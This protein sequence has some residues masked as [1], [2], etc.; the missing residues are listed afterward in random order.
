MAQPTISSPPTSD[1]PPLDALDAI[2]RRVLWLAMRMID[3][4]NRERPNP[5]AVKVGGHQASSASMVTLMTAMYFHW[6]EAGDRVAVKPHASPVLHS[7]NYLLGRLDRR[8][9]TTLRDFG[10]L[11]SY[12]SRTKDPDPVDFSTG[13]VGLGAAAPLF[14]G[15][16]D[17][18]L[19][20]QF[21]QRSGRRFVALVGDAELDEGNVWEAISD[22]ATRGLGGV[23]WIIDFNRQSLDRVVPGIRS[24]ELASVFADHGWHVVTLKYGPRLRAAFALDGGETL[25]KRI[26]EMPNGEYQSLLRRPGAEIRNALVGGAR[27]AHRARLARVLEAYPDE[28]LAPLIGDLGGHDLGDV[29]DGLRACDAETERPSVIFA[30]TVKGWGL[31]I[32]GHPL[33]HSAVLSPAQIDELRTALADAGDEWAG[34]DPA[35]AEGELCARSRARMDEDA[36]R[37]RIAL[38]PDVVP[39]EL[40]DTWTR[41]TSSQEAFARTLQDLAKIEP[42]ARHVVTT[43]PDV[44]ISTGLGG[45]INRR[46][47][48]AP[49]EERVYEQEQSTPLRWE[50]SPT[51][52][53]LELGIS[54]MNLFL[55]LGQLGMAYELQD[56]QLLPIGTVYDPFVCRGLDALIYG[57]YSGARF[58]VA[59]TPSG[60]SLSREGGAHQSAIT[61]SIG[62][63]LPGLVYWEPC[64]S[65]ET[66]WVLLQALRGLCDREAGESH[67]LR[68]ST[69]PVDQAPFLDWVERAGRERARNA[70]LAGAYRLAEAPAG[71]D[72]WRTV[73]ATCGALVPQALAAREL[74]AEE[75]VGA[76]VV[77]VTSPDLVFRA[78]TDRVRARSR[79]AR[80]PATVLDALVL[81]EERSAPLVTVQDAAPHALSFLAGALRMPLVPLGVDRFGQVGSQGAIYDWLDISAEAICEAALGALAEST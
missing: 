38:D 39:A 43:S 37:P 61:A 68:L 57:T 25:R 2:Q 48:F 66:E 80:P 60:V 69:T 5:D 27:Q 77:C 8:Y 30:F 59:G 29:I 51:G 52:Q 21:G 6:L 3:Y 45:W 56:V 65:L 36:E 47:V 73:I 35:S 75:E 14:A 64:F 33:N 81:P 44:S 40:G 70:V 15:V 49:T 9:L 16:V 58:V 11:Q 42:L 7:I 19:Q 62:S 67:Y 53:H 28:E 76:A 23:T 13:S 18:Y 17:R 34:F 22:P 20:A 46:G 26:D 78:V 41:T 1:A 74:L 79:G 71:L 10:G 32:A 63:E 54:E 31:P 4:A 72:R 24:S 55:L 12:P 50:P